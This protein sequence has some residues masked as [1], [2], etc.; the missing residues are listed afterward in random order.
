MYIYSANR[1]ENVHNYDI[2]CPEN[3]PKQGQN[4]TTYELGTKTVL[5]FNTLQYK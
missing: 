5:Y 3:G 2:C 4:K 1:L